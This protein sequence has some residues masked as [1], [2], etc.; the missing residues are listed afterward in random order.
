MSTKS[1]FQEIKDLVKI[2]WITWMIM[3]LPGFLFWILAF[4]GWFN[5]A[6]NMIITNSKYVFALLGGLLP[7]FR[8]R[9]WIKS[10]NISNVRM[11]IFFLS[12]H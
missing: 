5:N 7:I 8:Y 10:N 9:D 4:F 1:A 11:I 2:S 12:V 6:P 3:G